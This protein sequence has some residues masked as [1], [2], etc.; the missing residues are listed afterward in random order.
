MIDV[1][2]V[3][4][5]TRAGVPPKLTAVAPPR[6]VPVMVTR[7]PPRAEPAAGLTAVTVGCA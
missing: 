5:N 3:T 2:E 6:L 7:V 4:V 1:A